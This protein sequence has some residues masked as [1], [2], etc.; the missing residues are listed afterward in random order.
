MFGAP[1]G[2]TFKGH[3]EHS[4]RLGGLIAILLFLYF[5]IEAL[6]SLIDVVI[7]P[8]YSSTEVTEHTQYS[9]SS[10]AWSMST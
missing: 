2:I 6:L 8:E 9:E 4:T 3:Y 1:V 7:N 5:G 10:T